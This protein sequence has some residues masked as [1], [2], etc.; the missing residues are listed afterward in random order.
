[1]HSVRSQPA[2]SGV[3]VDDELAGDLVLGERTQPF[4]EVRANGSTPVM[5]GSSWPCETID[6]TSEAI[7]PRSCCSIGL[8]DA[9]A[10]PRLTTSMLIAPPNIWAAADTGGTSTIV[11]SCPLYARRPRSRSAS[12]P[13]HR[14]DDEVGAASIGQLAHTFIDVLRAVV[15]DGVCARVRAHSRRCASS[16]W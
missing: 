6:R 7:V 9:C 3:E 1:M 14:V 16:M 4:D 10:P 2:V 5:S 13:P 8:P 11:T 12:S 15:D